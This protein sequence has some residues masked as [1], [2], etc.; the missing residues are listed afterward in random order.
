MVDV[1]GRNSETAGDAGEPA[2][3]NSRPAS[4]RCSITSGFIGC[5]AESARPIGQNAT[6]QT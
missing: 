4:R 5:T 1:D 3:K 2:R 6:L